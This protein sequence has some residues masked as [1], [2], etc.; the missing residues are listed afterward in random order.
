M[1]NPAPLP[2]EEPIPPAQVLG[3]P[4]DFVGL[5][6]G[7]VAM[8]AWLTLVDVG[9]NPEA[10]RLAGVL[11][12]TITWWITEPVPIAVTGLLSIAVC[13]FIGA[14]PTAGTKASAVEVAF[15]P[16]AHPTTFF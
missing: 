15:A 9:L 12:L 5:V 14:V 3:L 7:P 2:V 4:L 11:L 1:I 10:H 16:F 8:I 6:L 13:V